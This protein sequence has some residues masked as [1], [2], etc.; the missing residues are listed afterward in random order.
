MKTQNVFASYATL[1][2]AAIVLTACSGPVSMTDLPVYPGATEH[3]EGQSPVGN[4]LAKNAQTDAAMR[5]A[6]GVGG[7]TEQKGYRLPKAAKW[8]DVKRFY[9]DKLKAAGWSSGTGGIMGGM[10][11]D[12]MNV[13]NKSNTQSQTALYSKGKQSL[14]VIVVASPKK[15]ERDLLLSLSTN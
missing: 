15:G 3:K 7:K 2:V 11:S 4:T 12:V 14:T 6:V 1:I 13:A 5:S 10:A 8:D 9:D